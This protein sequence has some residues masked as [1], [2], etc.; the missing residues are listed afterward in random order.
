MSGFQFALGLGLIAI[1]AAVMLYLG[2]RWIERPRPTE[3]VE[4]GDGEP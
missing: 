3:P 1:G 4:H 2:I